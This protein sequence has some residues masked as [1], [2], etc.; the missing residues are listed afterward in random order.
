MS[1]ETTKNTKKHG[2]YILIYE[3]MIHTFQLSLNQAMLL[4]IIYGFSQSGQG[5]QGSKQLFQ[6]WTGLSKRSV[7]DNLKILEEKKLIYKEEGD[8]LFPKYSANLDLVDPDPEEAFV[9]LRDFMITKHQLK[10][11]ELLVYALL[12]SF[13]LDDGTYYGGYAYLERWTGCN[14]TTIWRVLKRIKEKNLIQIIDQRQQKENGIHIQIPELV[15]KTLSQS[16]PKQK[17]KEIDSFTESKRLKKLL[18]EFFK[19]NHIR[20]GQIN[21][22]LKQLDALSWQDDVRC[23]IVEQSIGRGWKAFYPLRDEAPN[24]KGLFDI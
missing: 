10:K 19:T 17:D 15:K 2:S 11:T 12:F 5:Y 13:C 1:R 7:I 8:G 4:G 16:T 14:R 9:V 20:D 6:F 23:E 21:Y 3:S 24:D 18:K 22:H